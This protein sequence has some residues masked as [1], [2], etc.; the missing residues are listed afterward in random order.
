VVPET[1]AIVDDLFCLPEKSVAQREVGD[2][3]GEDREPPDG[4]AEGHG[5]PP[6]AVDGAVRF[7]WRPRNVLWRLKNNHTMNEL[8]KTSDRLAILLEEQAACIERIMAL[9]DK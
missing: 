2:A 6:R 4:T 9:L 1:G 8:I 5:V 7:L 3:D